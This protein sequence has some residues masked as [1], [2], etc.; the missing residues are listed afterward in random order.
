M[1]AYTPDCWKFL[2]IVSEECG[3]I[4]KLMSGNYGG[5]G[6]SDD[7]NIN[8]GIIKITETENTY[9]VHGL[10]GSVYTCYKNSE[11]MSGYMES[12]FNHFVKQIEESDIRMTM[13]QVSREE[14][15][16]RFKV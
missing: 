12:M 1:R 14:V 11:K 6:G 13:E 5:Y 8:S 16:R 10:S 4:Y 9:E 2:K 3:T 7:W 15:L